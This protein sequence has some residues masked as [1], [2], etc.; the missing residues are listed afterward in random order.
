MTFPPAPRHSPGVIFE[1]VQIIR[2]ESR[3]RAHLPL[4]RPTMDEHYFL[5]Y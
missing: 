5:E 2:S 3:V 1:R 4:I